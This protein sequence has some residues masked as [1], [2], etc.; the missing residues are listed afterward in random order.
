[1]GDLATLQ[2]LAALGIIRPVP[3]FNA[4]FSQA[5]GNPVAFFQENLSE[6]SA[7]SNPANLHSGSAAAA[8]AASMCEGVGGSTG[9]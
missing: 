3:Q 1:M 9:S 6:S 2:C 5:A 4:V 7:C 8:A